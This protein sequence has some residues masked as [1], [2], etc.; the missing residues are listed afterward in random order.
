[1][2]DLKDIPL[3]SISRNRVDLIAT[4]GKLVYIYTKEVRLVLITLP[5]R[6]YN[7]LMGFVC[8]NLSISLLDYL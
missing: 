3:S 8:P 7:Y 4:H 5:S 2:Q 1:M 6:M